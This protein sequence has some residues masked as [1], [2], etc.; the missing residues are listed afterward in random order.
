MTRRTG[1]L[2]ALRVARARRPGLHHD[3][4]GLYLQVSESG[5][6]S[7]IFRY[8]LRWKRRAMGL[9]P[10]SIVSLAEAR[11]AAAGCRRQLWEG[12][13]PLEERKARR[14]RAKLEAANAL[15]FRQCAEAYI[16]AHRDGWRNAKHMKQ[17]P[18]TLEA[19]VYPV[20]GDLPV[21][22]VD[23]GLVLRALEPVWSTRGV[24]AGRVRGRV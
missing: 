17:W 24:T 6:R 14:A 4:D 19:Y 12:T 5:A 23:V 21:Q 10:A 18:A 13:D 8:M 22:Q 2:T 7:W 1:K 11:I 15:T 9:G 16:A 20:F 3:G